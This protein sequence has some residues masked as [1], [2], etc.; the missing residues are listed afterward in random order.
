MDGVHR[1]MVFLRVVTLSHD[2]PPPGKSDEMMHGQNFDVHQMNG[3]VDRSANHVVPSGRH[4]VHS[5]HVV[6]E[7]WHS[8]CGSLVSNLLRH[9]SLSLCF[10]S[11]LDVVVRLFLSFFLFRT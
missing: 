3:I 11:W 6:D 1:F 4:V 7:A 8:C 2:P 5:P 9:L 10:Y